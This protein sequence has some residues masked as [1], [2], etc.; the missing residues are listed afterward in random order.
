MRYAFC[1]QYFGN[2]NLFMVESAVMIF[3]DSMF[4]TE[5]VFTFTGCTKQ[6]YFFITIPT[7]FFIILLNYFNLGFFLNNLFFDGRFYLQWNLLYDGILLY[8]DFE[9]LRTHIVCLRGAIE[10]LAF[11]T[12]LHLF[13]LVHEYINFYLISI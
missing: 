8:C 11:L 10:C 12:E 4:V 2:V 3:W 7:S 6:S 5:Y 9:A 13:G 1:A